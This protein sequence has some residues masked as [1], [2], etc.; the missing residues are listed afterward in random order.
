[1][2][3]NLGDASLEQVLERLLAIRSNLP[4]GGMLGMNMLRLGSLRCW[5]VFPPENAALSPLPP[6]PPL[7]RPVYHT[8]DGGGGGGVLCTVHVL[9]HAYTYCFSLCTCTVLDVYCSS[10]YTIVY[11]QRPLLSAFHTAKWHSLHRLQTGR[12]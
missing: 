8:A 2:Q 4:W 3:I 1:M 11:T 9:H 6:S 5:R 10:V 7:N 12:I